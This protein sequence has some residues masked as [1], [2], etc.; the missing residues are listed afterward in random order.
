[1]NP[2]S[3]RAQ[4]EATADYYHR[5]D[6][7]RPKLQDNKPLKCSGRDAFLPRRTSA[8]INLQH[9]HTLSHHCMLS[10]VLDQETL[11]CLFHSSYQ[12][13]FF[14][15]MWGLPWSAEGMIRMRRVGI[16]PQMLAI[17]EY[18]H[19]DKEKE[20]RTH[21]GFYKLVMVLLWFPAAEN[22]YCEGNSK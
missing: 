17:K 1:M 11:L 14:F 8:W 10:L 20:S 7:T 9:A 3:L 12:E 5:L 16:K 19:G 18:P 13:E 4:W 22:I 6:C 21:H 15:W 2:C